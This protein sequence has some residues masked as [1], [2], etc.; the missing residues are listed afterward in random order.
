MQKFAQLARDLAAAKEK[1]VEREEEV[2][3]LKSERANTRVGHLINQLRVKS[4]CK[5]VHVRTC[6]YMPGNWG[7]RD[8]WLSAPQLPACDKFVC[9][10]PLSPWGYMYLTIMHLHPFYGQYLVS[11]CLGW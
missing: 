8:S 1:V 9:L 11:I 10:N 7:A 3:E 2:Q 6:I 4:I 5:S